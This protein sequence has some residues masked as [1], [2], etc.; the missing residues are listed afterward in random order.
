MNDEYGIKPI[1]AKHDI[2][3]EALCKDLS[4]HFD[5][6]CSE[7]MD[8]HDGIMNAAFEEMN[9]CLMLAVMADRKGE[10]T[11]KEGVKKIIDSIKEIVT[12]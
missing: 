11:L 9:C 3:N 12:E 2:S 4:E 5:R 10:T 8:S 1:L 6:F 7:Y